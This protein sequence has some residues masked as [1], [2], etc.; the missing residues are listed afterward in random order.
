MSEVKHIS[1]RL[2]WHDDGWNGKICKDPLANTYCTGQYSFP[3]GLSEKKAEQVI[4]AEKYAG[5]NCS[6]IQ[7]DH[8]PPCSW[9]VNAFGKETIK[10]NAKSPDWYTNQEVKEWELPPNTV[11]LWSYEEMYQ[12]D[13]KNADVDKKNYNK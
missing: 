12:D 8:I 9:S 7:N 4:E 2:A 3:G 10:A 6:A 11:S 1:A 13:D 5:C